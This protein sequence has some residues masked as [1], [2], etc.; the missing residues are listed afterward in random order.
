MALQN[1]ILQ[2]TLKMVLHGKKTGSIIRGSKRSFILDRV[3]ESYINSL[4]FYT[5]IDITK[6]IP[7]Y[8]AIYI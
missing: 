6:H 8:Y 4:Q 5:A 1:C 7:E 3:P 2:L